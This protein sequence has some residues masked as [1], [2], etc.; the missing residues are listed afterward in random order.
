MAEVKFYRRN[1]SLFAT[2]RDILEFSHLFKQSVWDFRV[3]GDTYR[4]DS[5]VGRQMAET[6][7]GESYISYVSA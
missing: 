6:V 5:W 4:K 2:V 1:G 3:N 7:F